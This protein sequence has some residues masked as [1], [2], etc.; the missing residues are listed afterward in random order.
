MASVLHSRE[1]GAAANVTLKI[2]T[3]HR[4][5]AT[6]LRLIGRIR[7]HHVDELDRLLT[8]SGKDVAL[9]LEEVTLV[10]IDAVKFLATCTARGIPLRNCLAY[11]ADW[12]AKEREHSA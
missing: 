3:H 10:D 5:G 7:A 1:G 2:E 12:I 11:I 9:D 6:V 8:R 4:G